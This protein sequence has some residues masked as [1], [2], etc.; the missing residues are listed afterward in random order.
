MDFTYRAWR[1]GLAS[2]LLMQDSGYTGAD[3]VLDRLRSSLTEPE[4]RSAVSELALRF[5]DDVPAV[6][7]S[8]LEVTRAVNTRFDIDTDSP[9]PMSDIRNWKPV[10]ETR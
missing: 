9:D 3:S 7:L 4:I 6:F 1:S 5:H 8:W 2:H 10:A